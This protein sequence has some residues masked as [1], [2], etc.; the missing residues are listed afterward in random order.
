MARSLRGKSDQP[1]VWIPE[2]QTPWSLQEDTSRGKWPVQMVN[3]EMSHEWMDGS[4]AVAGLAKVEHREDPVVIIHTWAPNLEGRSSPDYPL[5]C[6]DGGQLRT[7][8]YSQQITDMMHCIFK[9]AEA[10]A[11]EGGKPINMYMP[12]VGQGFYV[13]MLSIAGQDE[14]LKSFISSL[15]SVAPKYTKV[16]AKLV[17]IKEKPMGYPEDAAV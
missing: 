10:Y 4:Y 1:F 14:A 15:N 13:S 9:A 17:G 12:M 6:G 2:Q 7:D 5:L 8:I 3:I 11:S 16:N